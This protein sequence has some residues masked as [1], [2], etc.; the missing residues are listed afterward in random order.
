MCGTPR[1]CAPGCRLHPG[2]VL[3]QNTNDLLFRETC[4]LHLSV[5]ERQAIPD[6]SMIH[7]R[8]PEMPE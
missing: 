3:A 4:S 6:S 7:D 2:F 5:P 8:P 1:A